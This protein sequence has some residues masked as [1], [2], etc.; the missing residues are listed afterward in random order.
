MTATE[1]RE[2]WERGRQAGR[3]TV[4]L[5]QRRAAAEMR[6]EGTAAPLL[7]GRRRTAPLSPRT[8]QE[9][10]NKRERMKRSRV[11]EGV[12]HRVGKGASGMAR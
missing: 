5:S 11:R 6:P 4:R 8:L 2:A 7:G 10:V 12:R 9:G 3:R 1:R